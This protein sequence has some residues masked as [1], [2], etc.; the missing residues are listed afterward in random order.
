MVDDNK[1]ASEINKYSGNITFS[2]SITKTMEIIFTLHTCQL[3]ISI[4]FYTPQH[5]PK[6]MILLPTVASISAHKSQTCLSYYS[7]TFN[8][9]LHCT[10]G[11]LPYNDRSG[12]IIQNQLRKNIQKFIHFP[13]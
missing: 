5:H 10:M 9:N 12:G 2:E 7:C 8:L 1:M 11:R 4:I 13:P 3:Y 6:T